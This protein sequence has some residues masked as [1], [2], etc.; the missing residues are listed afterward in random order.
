MERGGAGFK[1]L[2]VQNE[3][4]LMKIDFHLLV[5]GDQLWVWL[6]RAKYRWWNA[7]VSP[8]VKSRC[9]PLWISVCRVWYDVAANIS[10]QIGDGKGVRFWFD[11]WL[12][13]VGP[14]ADSLLNGMQLVYAEATVSDMMDGDGQWRWHRFESLLPYAILL[15]ITTVNISS[16]ALIHDFPRWN[17]TSHGQFRVH[18]TY[19]VRMGFSLVRPSLFGKR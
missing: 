13:S 15:R 5:K 1:R 2:Q 9:T 6:L 17:L 3:S 4:F 7:H 11:S 19:S 8:T 18:S 12:G 16:N 10:W 14:I